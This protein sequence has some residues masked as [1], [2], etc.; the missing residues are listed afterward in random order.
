MKKQITNVS[1]V[2]TAKVMAVLYL[3]I[4]LPFVLL[5][6]AFMPSSMG[7]SK[8]MLLLAPVLYMVIGFIFTLISAFIYNFVA[9]LVGGFEFTV[10]EVNN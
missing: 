6:M 10:T 2:Q 1:P 3:I 5:A 4:T 7:M 9:G 8:M